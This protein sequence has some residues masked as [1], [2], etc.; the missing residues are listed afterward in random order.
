MPF[1]EKTTPAV[2]KLEQSLKCHICQHLMKDPYSIKNCDHSFCRSCITKAVNEDSKCPEC[3]SIAWVKDLQVNRE[4]AGTIEF[5]LGMRNV[6][7]N[8]QI[9]GPSITDESRTKSFD[10]EDDKG[11]NRKDIENS[12]SW[13][14]S[15]VQAKK[16]TKTYGKKKKR[17]AET[18]AET[19]PA[20]QEISA[21]KT[22]FVNSK[23]FDVYNEDCVLDV[24]NNFFKDVP[25]T[26][27]GDCSSKNSVNEQSA[28][29][30]TDIKS[31]MPI[32]Q[33]C[34]E[35]N[36][37]DGSFKLKDKISSATKK[38]ASHIQGRKERAKRSVRTSNPSPK[39]ACRSV[40]SVTK[41][42]KK[43]ET[44]LHVAAIKGKYDQVR[45]LLEK[46]ADP[47]AKDFAGWT[48]LHEACNH[49]CLEIVQLLLDS[50]AFID[51]PGCD[52]D[53][54]L[55]DAI[56]NS[57]LEVAEFLIS[58]GASLDVRNKQG[59]LP[60]DYVRSSAVKDQLMLAA[61]MAQENREANVSINLSGKIKT[62]H[63]MPKCIL[64]T[65]LDQNKK[66][67]LARCT[68]RLGCELVDEFS[69]QVTHVVTN[70]DDQLICSRTIK[71]FHGILTGK[72][73][74]SFQWIADSLKKHH[75]VDEEP[76]EVRGCQEA[77]ESAPMKA[78]L[79]AAKQFPPLFDG[80]SFFFS[81][82]FKSHPSKP[83]LLS[84]VQFGGGTILHREP[85]PET[86]HPLITPS[87]PA[88]MKMM[89]LKVQ[90]SPTIAYHAK[91][92]TSQSHCTQFIIFD[93]VS[94]PDHKRLSTPIMCTAPSTWIL[95]CISNFELLEVR[96]A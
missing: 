46:G 18:A 23:N 50:G 26:G 36:Q 63:C 33:K 28:S 78:R 35:A 20:F 30:S 1:W 37:K 74:V 42:N 45:E 92:N 24:E 72:W 10:N 66:E 90:E 81:G 73:I 86:S 76:Y 56:A 27:Q 17:S 5:C 39:E 47:N 16:S 65:G 57:R 6:I 41:V 55:H 29:S 40:C 69:S 70:V 88:V 93:P 71:Y 82:D 54:P 52:H 87:S 3:G 9:Q 91:P 34:T 32:D 61:T 21:E 60:M 8:H 15:G 94:C 49:G 77:S 68:K 43:G 53:T 44:P 67:I 4:L 79:N 51:V 14:M 75:W 83:D 85:K 13:P 31:V 64:Q 89:S 58:K 12:P 2:D 48:P 59:L 22:D 96:D 11:D 7:A 62:N 95:D 38:T 84:L 25:A 80:C 19:M